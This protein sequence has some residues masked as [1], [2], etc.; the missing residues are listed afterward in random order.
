MFL[1]LEI[2]LEIIHANMFLVSE[3]FLN[4]QYWEM[5]IL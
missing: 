5:A 1:T 4:Y 3:K 2:V